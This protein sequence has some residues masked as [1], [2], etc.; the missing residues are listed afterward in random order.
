MHQ[1]YNRVIKPLAYFIVLS[2]SG[3]ASANGIERSSDDIWNNNTEKFEN[4]IQTSDAHHMDDHSN[5]MD[6]ESNGKMT[7][8]VELFAQESGM[9]IVVAERAIKA[10]DEFARYADRV[11]AR[12]PDKIARMWNEP[13]PSTKSHIQFVGKVSDTV[14]QDIFQKKV[15]H[16]VSVTGGATIPLKAQHKRAEAAAKGLRKAGYVNFVIIL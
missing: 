3:A 16:G 7:A 4:V 11:I 5:S 10:Q 2:A 1:R 15:P 13:A 12:Y 6:K 9:T 14:I 8:D